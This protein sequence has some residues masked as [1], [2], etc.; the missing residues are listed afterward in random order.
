MLRIAV[1]DDNAQFLAEFKARIEAWDERPQD[2]LLLCFENGDALI[3]VHQ[4]A[5]FDIILLDIVM[6]L[7][8]GL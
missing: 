8:N 5:P 2:M 1:C 4:K 7:I 6:P 3:E